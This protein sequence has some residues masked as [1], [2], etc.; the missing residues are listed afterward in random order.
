M[1][2]C[3]G[4]GS[5]SNKQSQNACDLGKRCVF[6]KCDSCPEQLVKCSKPDCKQRVHPLCARKAFPHVQPPRPFCS[7][8]CVDHTLSSTNTTTSSKASSIPEGPQRS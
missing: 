3:G 6:A 4:G 1:P 8:Q 7:T 2:C 5:T